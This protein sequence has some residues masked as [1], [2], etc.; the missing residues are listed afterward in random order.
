[1]MICIP[2]SSRRR[3]GKSGRAP[4]EFRAYGASLGHRLQS[5]TG[6][7]MIQLTD[8]N[9][10]RPP[11][12]AASAS[13]SK[14]ARSQRQTSATFRTNAI[15]NCRFQAFVRTTCDIHLQKRILRR[16]SVVH[17]VIL[18]LF[19]NCIRGR[20]MIW[21]AR[22]VPFDL[23]TLLKAGILCQHCALA[24]PL[25]FEIVKSRARIISLNVCAY[26]ASAFGER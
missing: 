14:L 3:A 16:R 7:R 20:T 17:A 18:L 24:P 19:K 12:C 1:M 4:I 13:A 2:C 6:L 25:E 22:C 9:P 21:N 8:A 5:L 15:Q 10:H 11:I 26:L 23:R